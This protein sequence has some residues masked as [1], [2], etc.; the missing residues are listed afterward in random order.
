MPET[1]EESGPDR[2][3]LRWSS[4]PQ[5]KHKHVIVYGSNIPSNGRATCV[6]RKDERN[7]N[8]INVRHLISVCQ[9]HVD[10]CAAS[11]FRCH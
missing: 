2:R 10:K 6:D 9:K 7:K 11:C 5:H 4:R 1:P 3:Q 8:E